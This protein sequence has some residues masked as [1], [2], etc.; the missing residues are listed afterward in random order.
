MFYYLI[1]LGD[2]IDVGIN[3]DVFLNIMMLMCIINNCDALASQVK[4]VVIP[5]AGLFLIQFT[6]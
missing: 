4:G 5:N 6:V 2:Y 1:G 3:R